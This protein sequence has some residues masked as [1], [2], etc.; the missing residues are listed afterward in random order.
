METSIT[1]INNDSYGVS[2]LKNS[3][4]GITLRGFIIAIS[5]HILIIISYLLI[6]YINKV[7]AKDIPVN[8]HEPPIFVDIDIPPSIEDKDIPPVKKEDIK[9]EKDLSSLKPEPVKKIIADNVLIKTQNELDKIEG[10]TSRT[11]DSSVFAYNNKT[12]IDDN[13]IDK[14]IDKNIKDPVIKKDYQSYEVEVVPVC[15]NL[16][17]VK[18]SIEYPKLA[19]DIGEEGKVTV[20]VLVNENGTVS[21]V[22]S[23]TGPDIFYDEVKQKAQNLVFTPGLQNNQAVKVW[24]TVPFNF[25]MK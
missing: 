20:K 23:L 22:G 13:T 6:S 19:Q 8:P 18:S 4:Q 5:L 16:A 24:M 14:N 9:P 25:K 7:N 2:E 21:K 12:N 3:Y 10:Q 17:Q 15:T 1:L 11:G